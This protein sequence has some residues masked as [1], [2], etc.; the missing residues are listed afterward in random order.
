LERTPLDLGPALKD[1]WLRKA[2][3]A[4]GCETVELT[5]HVLRRA[6][7]SR[8]REQDRVVGLRF[9]GVRGLA[10]EAVR[11]DRDAAKW[12]SAKADWL[13]ALARDAIDRPIVGIAL[14]NQDATLERWRKGAE[15]ALWLRGQ[16]ANLDA[17]EPGIV[18]TA[19]LLFELTAEV[20][21]PSGVNAN[22][23]LFVAAD[24]LDAIGSKGPTDLAALVRAGEDWAAKWRD[25]W[26]RRERRP[27][28]GEDP[29]FE[30]MQPTEDE[31]R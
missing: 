13:G 12:V 8:E 29:Q 22:A 31:L 11:W 18:A 2:A 30:W 25:Y 23:R 17:A 16:P 3:F 6:L 7:G 24:A 9:R 26:R 5:I 1:A 28:L 15:G 21:L 20:I 14:V 4:R 27:E 10:T 19:P